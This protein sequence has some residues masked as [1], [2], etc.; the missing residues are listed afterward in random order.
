MNYEDAI[1]KLNSADRLYRAGKV[2]PMSDAEWDSLYAKVK[3]YEAKNP[4]KVSKKSP[5]QRVGDDSTSGFAKVE[6]KVPMISLDKSHTIDELSSALE[7]MTPPYCIDEKCDGAA[8]SLHYSKGKLVQAVTRGKGNVGDDV[9]A[10]AL[11]I[12]SIPKTLKKAV[13]L[14]VR[15]EVVITNDD[16][17]LLLKQGL[18]FANARNAASGSL[19]LKNAKEVASRRLTFLAYSY[20]G[21]DKDHDA[22]MKELKELGFKTT[23]LVIKK[24]TVGVLEY[25]KSFSRDSVPYQIDG[26]V[27]KCNSIKAQKSLGLSKTAPRWAHAFKFPA[28]EAETVVESVSYQVGRHGHITPVANVTAV[29]LAGTTVRRATLH[30]FEYCKENGI[31]V[32]SR[33]VIIKSGDIIPKVIAVKSK[34]TAIRPLKRC[35]VCGGATA[36]DNAYLTCTNTDC[37][38]KITIK[39]SHWCSRGVMDIR[40]LGYETLVKLYEDLGVKSIYDLY[41]LTKKKLLS[42]EG[43]QDKSANNI[44]SE[45]EKSKG[46]EFWRTING[47][48]IHGVGGETAKD[49]ASHFKSMDALLSASEADLHN[50]N[51]IG[52]VTAHSIKQ[53]L[54]SNKKLISSLEGVG[55]TMKYSKPKGVGNS[56]NG[57]TLCATGTLSKKREEIYAIIESNGGKISNSVSAKLNYLIVGE[58][59]GSKASNAEKLGVTCITEAQLTKMINN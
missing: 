49:L 16:F 43:I 31:G 41:K 8:L 48:S 20:V 27:I 44:L 2:S 52:E 1:K 22:S 35:P 30:N 6:H 50:V 12:K 7:N 47:L 3:N 57:K 34:G 55:I 39:L 24:S 11:Q 19:K 32:G 26:L 45:I 23:N 29:S 4:S 10:N 59:G 5:T 40:S 14:E 38:A 56:L 13:S 15:G 46:R 51:G 37:D 25:C 58:G 54:K 33:I 17:E 21:S 28:D 42:V 36:Q 53:F 9:T 18:P